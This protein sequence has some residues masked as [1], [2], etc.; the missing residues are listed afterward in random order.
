MSVNSSK[1]TDAIVSA[2]I[3][4]FKRDGYVNVSVSDICRCADV[5]RS[6]FYSI[7]A[8]KDEII[9]YLLRNIK[10]DFRNAVSLFMDASNDLDRIWML[11]D[12]YLSLAIEFG[13]EL[14]ATL[15]SLELQQPVGVF[16][17]IDSFNEWFI[18]LIRNCQASGLIRNTNRPEDIVALGTRIAV[19]VIFEW[20][21][22]G[23]SFDLHEVSY[24]EHEIFYD[25]PHEYSKYRDAPEP[26]MDSIRRSVESCIAQKKD[27]IHQTTALSKKLLKNTHKPS[28]EYSK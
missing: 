19:A 4:L 14:T 11:Y 8:G 12:R 13:P 21:R 7:F 23:G 15:F 18:K 6:S 26:S 9:T 25:V 10:D 5:P 20:C 3:E 24:R 28:S 16:D 17:F 22:T 1:N 27:I 2:A